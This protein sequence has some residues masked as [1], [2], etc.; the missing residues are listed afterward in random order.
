MGFL[1]ALIPGLSQAKG[2]YPLRERPFAPGATLIDAIKIYAAPDSPV[3]G[4]TK[5]E[6]MTYDW[7]LN[8]PS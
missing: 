8:K 4:A 3:N 2:P 6:A 1:Y 5:Y 7:S